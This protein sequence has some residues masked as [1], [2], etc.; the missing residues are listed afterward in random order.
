MVPQAVAYPSQAVAILTGG[1]PISDVSISANAIWTVGSNAHTGTATLGA[2]GLYESRADLALSGGN[3]IEIS[4][5]AGYP[6]SIWHTEL[7]TNG[8]VLHEQVLP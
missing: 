1:T 7:L 5:S 3:H 2:N 8:E 4:T 6:S